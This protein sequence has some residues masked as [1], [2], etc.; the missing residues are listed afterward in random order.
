MAAP[1]EADSAPAAFGAVASPDVC[2]GSSRCS[3]SGVDM[4]LLLVVVAWCR[5]GRGRPRLTCKARGSSPRLG[6]G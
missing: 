3:G 6:T 1:A 2:A 4:L 5:R